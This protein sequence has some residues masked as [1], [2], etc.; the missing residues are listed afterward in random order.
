MGK[1]KDKKSKTKDK[2]YVVTTGAWLLE[3]GCPVSKAYSVE[4]CSTYEDAFSAMYK[5]IEEL[6]GKKVIIHEDASEIYLTNEDDECIGKF[7]LTETT[8]MM[9]IVGI[10][11]SYR[12]DFFKE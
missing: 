12:V 6:F 10:D 11:C 5:R 8:G 1:K 3:D 9:A 4:E 2:F 7:D